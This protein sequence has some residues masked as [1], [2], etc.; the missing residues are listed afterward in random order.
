[1]E[2]Q[3]ISDTINFN[4]IRDTN[5]YAGDGRGNNTSGNFG[6]L[7]DPNTIRIAS[8]E[9]PS[10]SWPRTGTNAPT[11]YAGVWGKSGNPFPRSA[12]GPKGLQIASVDF[13]GIFGYPMPGG[14]NSAQG[15]QAVSINDVPD[16]TSN[17]AMVGEVYRGIPF[18]ETNGSRARLDFTGT[19][20]DRWIVETGFCGAD[21]SVPPNTALA[22]KNKSACP[23]P[24]GSPSY[25]R[26]DDSPATM[27]CPDL[28]HWVDNHS[29]GNHGRRPISS[30]HPGGALAAWTDGSVKFVSQTVNQKVWQN[31]GTRFGR[32]T[33]TYDN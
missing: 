2:Q 6:N 11:N 25:D 22:V 4:K 29:N 8:Y 9:C 27:P 13:V 17:T 31:T 12:T 32:E 14:S 26:P 16:G 1:M 15:F 21:T 28:V 10:D 19:R 24:V 5:C 3:N 23:A 18:W 7:K 20:C 33:P 30:L